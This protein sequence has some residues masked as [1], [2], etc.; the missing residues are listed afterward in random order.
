MRGLKILFVLFL[1]CIAGMA[2]VF[3][4]A[5]RDEL[6]GMALVDGRCDGSNCDDA[7]V[8]ASAQKLIDAGDFDA[9]WKAQWCLGVV[10]MSFMEDAE[11]FVGPAMGGVLQVAR[12]PCGGSS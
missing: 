4:S 2:Y 1:F 7:V 9:A 11:G 3:Y 6:V 8:A 10:A 12:L 5:G